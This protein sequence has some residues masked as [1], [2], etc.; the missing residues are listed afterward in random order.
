MRAVAE[1]LQGQ[2]VRVYYDDFNEVETWGKDLVV[3]FDEVYRKQSEYCVIFMTAARH[4]AIQIP[5]LNS[6]PFEAGQQQKRQD[7]GKRPV[8]PT[9]RL[10]AAAIG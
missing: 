7:G 2:D 5:I 6:Y 1:F 10:C 4:G 8:N 9:P 3:R